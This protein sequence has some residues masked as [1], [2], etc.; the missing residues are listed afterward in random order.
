MNIQQSFK[1]TNE[2]VLYVVPTP[3]GN[4][5]DMT[6]RAVNTLKKAHVIAAED[7][8]HTK[9]LLNHF[10]IQTPL[11]SYH[12]HNERVRIQPFI[13]RMEKGET[14]A[15]VSD[16][17]MPAISDPGHMIVQAA[18]DAN[19]SVIV[20]PGANAAIC[21]LIGSGLPTEEFL[22]YGFL[23]RKKKEKIEELERLKRLKATLVFYESPYRVKESVQAIYEQLGD[24]HITIARELTKQFE[25][26]IRG[27]VSELVT[28]SGL[29]D[30]KGECCI[31][32][33]GAKAMAD[34]E[35]MLWWSHLSVKEHV[36]HYIKHDKIRSKEAIKRVAAERKM[37]S[38]DVYHVYHIE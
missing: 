3:I 30:L 12:E 38:R 4:L 17:G 5:D 36:D 32:V 8:R 26:Y 15:L 35:N 1:Q 6:F 10:S 23:P 27:K 24:R 9:K 22:F 14:I 7:T 37:G 33:E 19:I 29:N 25:T 18:I 20:L 28:W 34:D 16:A 11:I 2:G 31:V 13:E 21:A